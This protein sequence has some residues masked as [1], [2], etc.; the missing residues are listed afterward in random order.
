MPEQV[1]NASLEVAVFLGSRARKAFFLQCALSAESE[2]VA[3]LFFG[4]VFL[5]WI[6][7]SWEVKDAPVAH[8]PELRSM[9]NDSAVVKLSLH[10]TILCCLSP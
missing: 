6:L 1:S 5:Q 2:V 9:R 10:E 7:S 3:P 4:G 8:C